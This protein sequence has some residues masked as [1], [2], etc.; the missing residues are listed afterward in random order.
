MN[1]GQCAVLDFE[2]KQ[3]GTGACVFFGVV[4]ALA[5][6]LDFAVTPFLGELTETGFER[7]TAEVVVDE[8]G[9][10]AERVANPEHL[11]I[12][13]EGVTDEDGCGAALRL[14]VE[15]RWVWTYRVWAISGMGYYRVDCT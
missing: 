8:C 2:L 9:A 10:D 6:C 15:R 7:S 5:L 1:F 12:G 13:F 14:M 3:V 11:E 4:S